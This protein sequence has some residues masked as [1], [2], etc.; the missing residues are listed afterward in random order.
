MV[1]LN[2]LTNKAA[3]SCFLTSSKLLILCLL[4]TLSFSSLAQAKQY[5]I[6]FVNYSYDEYASR[7]SDRA[8]ERLADTGVEWVNILASQLTDDIDSTS[9]YRSSRNGITPSDAS[10]I[11]AI[12][13]AHSLGL[14]VMLYPHLEL[15]SDPEHLDNWFGQIGKN[16]DANKWNEWFVSYTQFLKHYVDIAEQNGVEQ[17]SV[18][19]ELMYAEKQEAHFRQLINTL[20]QQFSG[21]LIYAENYKPETDGVSTSNVRF[22]DALDFIGIDAYYDLIP[23]SNQNPTLNDMLEAW[24]PIVERLERYSAEWSKP[25][26]IPE[27]GYRSTKGA[28]HHPWDFT[29]AVS[30]DLQEQE[31][32]YKAF[33]QSFAD[34]PW[35]AGIIWWS[36]SADSSS[37]D[38][39][40]SPIG[41]P[42]EAVIRQYLP[43]GSTNPRNP[44][45]PSADDPLCST[46]LDPETIN[47]GEGT[48]LWWWSKNVHS[49]HMNKGIGNLSLPTEFEWIYPTKTTTYTMTAE[50]E[51][52]STIFCKTK[53]IVK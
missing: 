19:M 36:H 51:N 13:K 45:D 52:G 11:H 5:G 32:A 18:G 40:Y 46:G 2:K 12:N 29:P 42:A 7:K 26:F 53:I 31:N 30:I 38:D 50:G 25:I 6:A 39:G 33:Y 44:V 14:K 49:A 10:L 21:K 4:S 28:T 15:A 22:W 37:L 35:F 34:K 1:N 16:F 43:S 8:L 24:K 47:Q 48:A 41:K 20:R 23:E 27:L 9:I 17:F 3:P